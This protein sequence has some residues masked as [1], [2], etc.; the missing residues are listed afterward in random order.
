[1][2]NFDQIALLFNIGL[3]VLDG[4]C[5]SVLR[6]PCSGSNVNNIDSLIIGW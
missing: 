3:S 4:T 1:M 6:H 2:Y 5:F